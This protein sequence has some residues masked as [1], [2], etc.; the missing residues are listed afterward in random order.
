MWVTLAGPPVLWTCGR[1]LL[2]SPSWSTS[3]WTLASLSRTG[4]EEAGAGEA[5]L[6][7]LVLE[8]SSG[9]LEEG[10]DRGVEEEATLT[11]L[12]LDTRK[13]VWQRSIELLISTAQSLLYLSICWLQFL[14]NLFSISEV[15]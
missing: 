3:W 14:N 15:K 8:D 6:A 4:W 11:D 1:T 9:A 2:S 7:D 13:F 10:E 12:D 5:A